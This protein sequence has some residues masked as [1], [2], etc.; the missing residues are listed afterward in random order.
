MK[1]L[2]CI[3]L[4]VYGEKLNAQTPVTDNANNGQAKRLVFQQWDDWQ[5]TPETGFLG[6]PKDLMGWFYWRVLHNSYYNGEDS[7]P[8][9]PD[10]PF[11]QN[12]ASLTLQEKDDIHIRD[13]MQKVMETNAATYLSMSGGAAD[14]AWNMYFGKQFNELTNEISARLISISTKH[15]LAASKMSANRHYKEY[16]EYLDII[17]D[18]LETIHNSLVDRGER[19]ISYLEI[20]KEIQKKNQVM[21]RMI[22]SYIQ[23]TKMPTRNEIKEIQKVR[24]IEVNDAKIVKKI[25]SNFNF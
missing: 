18:K 4:L 24:T 1:K 22:N 8:Y 14:V 3:L 15:P 7:R 23:L 10:G 25:L 13:S 6:L 16:L 2:I 11:M 12:Y 9:R 5:P 19:I 17:N 21:Q 20:Q